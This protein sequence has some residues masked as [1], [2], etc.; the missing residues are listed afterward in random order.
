[1]IKKKNR[2][3]NKEIS[4][5]AWGIDDEQLAYYT[6]DATQAHNGRHAFTLTSCLSHYITK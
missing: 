5:E 6:E 1:M 2:S 3:S 4:V